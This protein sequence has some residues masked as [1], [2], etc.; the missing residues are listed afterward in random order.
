VN[1]VY[2]LHM[3]PHLRS[4]ILQAQTEVAGCLGTNFLTTMNGDFVSPSVLSGMDQGRSMVSVMNHLPITHCCF[5]NHEADIQLDELGARVREFGGVWLNSNMPDFRPQLRAFDI[6]KVNMGDAVVRVGLLGLLISTPG[7]FNKNKFRGLKI[8]DVLS[9][10]HKWSG[11]LRQEFGCSHVI[12]L[13]H[14]SIADDE[15]LAASGCVDLILGGHE[16][17]VI[18]RNVDKEGRAVGV[19]VVKSGSD[20]TNAAVIDMN[21]EVGGGIR[22]HMEDVSRF[23]AS[24]PLLTRVQSH[25]KMVEL[26]AREPICSMADLRPSIAARSASLSSVR[27]RYQQT[28]VGALLSGIIRDVLLVDVAMINGGSIK[29]NKTY[30]DGAISLLELKKELPFPTKMVAIDMPGKVLQAAVRQSRAG[31]GERRSFLQLDDGVEVAADGDTILTIAGIAFDEDLSYHVALPRNLL[32]GA[33]DIE[34]LLKYAKSYESLCL[35]EDSFVPALNLC[36]IGQAKRLWR[37]LGSFDQ[38]DLNHDGILSREEITIALREKLGSE[39]SEIMVDNVISAIDHDS[40]GTIS[41][42]EYDSQSASPLRRSH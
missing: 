4:L 35:D 24:P 6:V 37:Q 19:P 7:V 21:L 3:L 1:D 30:P 36:I 28:S 39:P 9:S 27:T 32:K 16:H 20:A 22:V 25:L 34:P 42:D 31:E 38:L 40:D 12:A 18:L 8:E 26:L 15:T 5:G 2:E 41:K 29:G 13:T 10:A 11:K 23:P 17:E 14:Q 33:F